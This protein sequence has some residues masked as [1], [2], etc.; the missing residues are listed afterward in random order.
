QAQRHLREQAERLQEADRRKNEFLA[1]LAHELR[2]PLA[3]VRNAVQILRLKGLPDSELHWARELIDRQVQHM[4]CMVDDLLDV[5]RIA[6][7]MI[8]LEKEP[9]ELATVVARAVEMVRPLV[10]SCKHRATVTLPSEPVWLEADLRRLVQVLANLLTNAAK[11]TNEG[12]K[13]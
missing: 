3:P 9:V 6:R 13:I 5:S 7:G 2:N 8:K 12:G 1:M 10:D 11:Y 4:A